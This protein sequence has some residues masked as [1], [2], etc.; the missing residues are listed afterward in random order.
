MGKRHRSSVNPVHGELVVMPAGPGVYSG[1]STK[2]TRRSARQSGQQVL[3]TLDQKVPA[4]MRED[5]EV[6]QG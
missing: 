3:R 6:A 2:K 5:Y 4:Q 1:S